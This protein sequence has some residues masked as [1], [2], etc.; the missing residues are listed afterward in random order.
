MAATVEQRLDSSLD[1][2]V[3][4]TKA[5]AAAGGTKRQRGGVHELPDGLSRACA[6]PQ[7][8]AADSMATSSIKI[9]SRVAC[10]RGIASIVVPGHLQEPADPSA[11]VVLA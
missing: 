1:Q 3:E 7:L 4:D 11:R 8:W 5:E 9:R 6:K 10:F 2:L